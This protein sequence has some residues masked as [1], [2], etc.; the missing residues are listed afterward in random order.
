MKTD[1]GTNSHVKHDA[2]KH[3]PFDRNVQFLKIIIKAINLSSKQ[4]LLLL[5]HRDNS[6]DLFSRDGNFLAVFKT[7]ADMDPVLKDHIEIGSKN[8]QTSWNIQNEI[9]S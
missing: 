9:I 6:G 2:I 8:A 3:K 1:E 7:L 5:C 4:G